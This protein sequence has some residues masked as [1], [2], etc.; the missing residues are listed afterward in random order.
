MK[1]SPPNARP[2]AA[3]LL[4][5][6]SSLLNPAIAGN[7]LNVTGIGAQSLAM[8]SADLAVP[9]SSVAIATNPANL[10]AIPGSRFD[11]S[12]EPFSTYGFS[13]SDDLN[14]QQKS[15]QQFGALMNASYAR[16]INRDLVFGMGMF[17]AGGSDAI[18]ADR[19]DRLRAGD[20]A[21][22]GLPEVAVE[23]VIHSVL[24]VNRLVRGHHH[25]HTAA[26]TTTILQ[27]EI[28]KAG[29]DA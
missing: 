24:G 26:Q 2:I 10:S 15:D 14:V 16:R 18:L 20:S 21:L 19:D 11:G 22:G 17:V 27:E 7:G 1:L 12:I 29:K 9:G 25:R 3:V 8:S 4:F 6:S 13:H 5:A 28:D 23:G